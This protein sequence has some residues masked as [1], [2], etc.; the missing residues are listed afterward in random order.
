MLQAFSFSNCVYDWLAICV[1]KCTCSVDVASIPHAVFLNSTY[2]VKKSLFVSA[3]HSVA[4]SSQLPILNLK[5]IYFLPNYESLFSALF[6]E[7]KQ[8]DTGT[9]LVGVWSW[10]HHK[11]KWIIFTFYSE[12]GKKTK[13]KTQLRKGLYIF[14]FSVLCSTLRQPLSLFSDGISTV[15]DGEIKVLWDICIFVNMYS[16]LYVQLKQL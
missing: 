14:Y 12:A 6:R 8:P 16:D 2:T 1:G 3:F 4:C 9:K 5:Y 11:V 7:K 10:S 13:T 15:Y